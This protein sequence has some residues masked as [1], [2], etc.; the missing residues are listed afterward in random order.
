[1]EKERQVILFFNILI[2]NSKI[3]LDIETADIETAIA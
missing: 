1:M 2:V 3:L